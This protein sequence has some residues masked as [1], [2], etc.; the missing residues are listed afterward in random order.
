MNHEV[1]LTF[2][3]PA[4]RL[5]RRE[6]PSGIT[7][8]FTQKSDGKISEVTIQLSTLAFTALLNQG[9]ALVPSPQPN[10]DLPT[11]NSCWREAAWPLYRLDDR[12]WQ[13]L[14]REVTGETVIHVLWFMKDVVLARRIMA[15]F[16]ERAAAMV[17]EDLIAKFQG[18]SPE[19]ALPKY[20]QDA[21]DSL[22]EMLEIVTRL[23]AEGQ[24]PERC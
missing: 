17:T 4:F 5:E 13:L 15:N 11:E 3:Q 22:Q 16:S 23:Q 24:I 18:K 1:T 6:Y 9:Q 14:L 12:D 20:L 21:R 7:L 10:L 19:D 2:D 8:E